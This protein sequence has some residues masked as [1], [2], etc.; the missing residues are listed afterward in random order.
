MEVATSTNYYSTLLHSSSSA[1]VTAKYLLLSA[2]KYWLAIIGNYTRNYIAKA[3]DN[4]R[5]NII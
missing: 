3:L 4:A 1:T 2:T 5:N